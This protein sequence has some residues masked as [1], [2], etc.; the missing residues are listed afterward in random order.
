MKIIADS[1]IRV[2]TLWGAV[3]VFEAGVPQEVCDD[4]GILALQLG[5]KQIA[6]DVLDPVPVVVEEPPVA[7][8]EAVRYAEA[9]SDFD[10]SGVLDALE[11]IVQHGDPNDFKSDGTP[12][13][14]AVTREVGRVVSPEV[15]EAAWDKFINS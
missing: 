12:K 9:P 14:S 6:S 5:A 7:A 15:R 1:D 11:K 13:A 2:A 3:V 10:M 8:P 4:I